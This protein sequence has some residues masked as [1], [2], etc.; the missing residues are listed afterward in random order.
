MNLLA[1]ISRQFEDSAQ[2][3]LAALEALAAPIAEAVEAMVG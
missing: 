1:R 2:T 3:K